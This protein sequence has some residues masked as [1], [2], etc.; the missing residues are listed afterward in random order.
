M[1]MCVSDW[2]RVMVGTYSGGSLLADDEDAFDK[3]GARV[4]DA[5]EYCLCKGHE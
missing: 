4:V 2:L 3:G 5:V 1:A